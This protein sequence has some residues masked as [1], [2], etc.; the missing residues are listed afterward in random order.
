MEFEKHSFQVSKHLRALKINAWIDGHPI[1]KVLVDG[2]STLNLIPSKLLRKLGKRDEEII[3]SNIQL[4]NFTGEVMEVKG[5]FVANLTVG[6][7]TSRI[8]FCV[9]EANASY[10][11]LLGRD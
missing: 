9:V 11:L 4:S 2:G 6:S 5:I 8:A 1:S 3:S 7:K 10:N